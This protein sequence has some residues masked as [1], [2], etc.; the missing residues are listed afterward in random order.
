MAEHARDR[1][2][3]RAPEAAAL[4]RDVDERDRRVIEAGVLVH[5]GHKVV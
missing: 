3:D 4:R 1:V 2:V 5:C